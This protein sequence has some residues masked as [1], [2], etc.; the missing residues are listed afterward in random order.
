M[1]MGQKQFGGSSWNRE[2]VE[3]GYQNAV[4]RSRECLESDQTKK[5]CIVL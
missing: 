4:L 1:M 2:E 5:C 3:I